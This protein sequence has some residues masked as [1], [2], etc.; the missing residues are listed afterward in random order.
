[1]ELKIGESESK[2]NV[3]FYHLVEIAIVVVAV[4]RVVVGR[5][6]S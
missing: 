3:D 4:G 2:K 1:M 5:V 6:G